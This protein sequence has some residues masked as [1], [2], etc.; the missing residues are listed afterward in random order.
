[1]K[2]NNVHVDVFENGRMAAQKDKN[3]DEAN[4]YTTAAQ[5]NSIL[6]NLVDSPFWPFEARRFNQIKSKN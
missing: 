6:I 5:L 2:K 3:P 4:W 1:M